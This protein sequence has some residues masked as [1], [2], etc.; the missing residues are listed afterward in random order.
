MGVNSIVVGAAVSVF[1]V[2]VI[3]FGCG[4][5]NSNC[6]S[7]RGFRNLLVRLG[8]EVLLRGVVARRCSS[9]VTVSAPTEKGWNT[10]IVWAF[11]SVADTYCI[12]FCTYSAS[13]SSSPRECFWLGRCSLQPFSRVG[14]NQLRTSC[15]H[16]K[17]PDDG[18]SQRHGRG[19]RWYSMSRCC[20]S[21]SRDCS[22]RIATGSAIA[23]NSDHFVAFFGQG[24]VPVKLIHQIRNRCR[25]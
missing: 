5:V 2:F 15:S 9:S 4:G 3:G 24:Y 19:S 25:K 23:R 17:D 22:C 12:C 14:V 10:S 8:N 18:A 6:S 16:S 13:T 11:R 20:C 7:S 21:I 1:G